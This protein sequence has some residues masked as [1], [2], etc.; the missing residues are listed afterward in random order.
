[1]DPLS[2]GVV[3]AIVAQSVAR[4]EELRAASIAGFAAGL[5]PDVDVFIRSAQDPLLYLDYHRH[6][7]H[8]LA[9]V[10]IGGAIAALLLWPV[11]RR[12]LPPRRLVLFCMLG[13]ATHGLLDAC[14]TYGTQLLWPFSDR[15]VAWN[16]V[17][18]VDPAFTLCVSALL[19]VALARRS[20]RWGQAAVALALAVL[21]VG[22]VQRERAEALLARVAANHGAAIERG[23][24]KPTFGNLLLWRGVW[25]TGDTLHVVALRPGVFG[26]DRVSPVATAPRFVPDRDVPA[27][28]ADDRQARD[29]ARFAH[30]SAGWLVRLPADHGVLIGD[31]RYAMLPDR[32]DPLWAIRL[33]IDRPDEHVDYVTQRQVLPDTL[34]RFACMIRGACLAP[35]SRTFSR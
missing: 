15:R 33:D 31:L 22:W 34:E 18:V 35:F 10:P 14:T 11:L 29:I 9:F 28:R 30:F 7:T 13:Y 23:G 16:I 4:R 5:L 12:W 19:V 32:I 6:F 3:G 1:V 17:S 27:L 20:A 21:T 2:Q 24:V 25:Q 8:A 26:P